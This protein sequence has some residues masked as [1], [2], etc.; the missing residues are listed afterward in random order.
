M[1][2]MG[3]RQPPNLRPY[4]RVEISGDRTRRE[5]QSRV[6]RLFARQRSARRRG[7][8][9]LSPECAAGFSFFSVQ[10]LTLPLGDVG[11]LRQRIGGLAVLRIRFVGGGDLAN[12]VTHR[13]EISTQRG[14]RQLQGVLRGRVLYVPAPNWRADQG[15][16]PRGIAIVILGQAAAVVNHLQ[17]LAVSLWLVESGSQYFVLTQHQIQRALQP[18]GLNGAPHRGQRLEAIGKAVRLC[19]SPEALLQWRQR[20]AYGREIVFG[21]T[22]DALAVLFQALRGR[23]AGVALPKVEDA[24]IRNIDGPLA[25][26]RPIRFREK[27]QPLL[28]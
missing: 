19:A 28:L 3:S 14:K 13:F 15:I 25:N 17:R 21:D 20:I 6:G 22:H 5:G 7:G 9:L 2:A 11:K 27:V 18:L 26:T 16:K 1:C 10:H 24:A 8:N 12:E 23:I 4:T